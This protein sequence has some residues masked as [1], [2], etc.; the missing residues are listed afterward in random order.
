[1]LIENLPW[2]IILLFGGG[3]GASN[4]FWKTTGLSGFARNQMGL[5]ED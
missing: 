1:M 2:G 5:L 3:H 4:R